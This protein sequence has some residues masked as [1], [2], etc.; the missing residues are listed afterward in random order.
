MELSH[1]VSDAILTLTGFFVFFRYIFKLDLAACLLWEAFILS[2]TV[3]AMF[4]VARFMGVTEATM[5]SEF[6]QH[7]AGTVGALCLVFVSFFLVLRK[8]VPIKFAYVV[9]LLGFLAFAAVRIYDRIEVLNAIQTVAIPLV[10]L[11]GVWGLFRKERAIGVW[12]VLAVIAVVMGTYNK[13]FMANTFI[14]SIDLY[15]YLLAISLLCF[16]R[17]ASHQVQG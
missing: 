12:L 2:V 3:A 6:F 17:A 10:L 13:R 15:H 14:D 8:P 5:V 9:G 16:G 1:A 7:L 11:I 4:G